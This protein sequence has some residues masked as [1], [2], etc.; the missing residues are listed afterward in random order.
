MSAGPRWATVSKSVLVALVAVGAALY[1]AGRVL[2]QDGRGGQAPASAP[3]DKPQPMAVSRL[4]DGAR[5]QTA[6]KPVP[7]STGAQMTPP[8]AG[9]GPLQ[10]LAITQ[11]DE[12]QRVEDLEGG[13][14]FSLSFAE[15]IPIRDLLLMLVRDTSLSIIPEPGLEGAFIG[16]LKNVTLRQALDLVLQPLGL[17]YSVEGNFIRV[18]KLRMETRIFDI[19]YV[20][21]RRAG[22]RA[23][24]ATTSAAG[25][26][27]A[28]GVGAGGVGIGF[29]GAAGGAGGAAGAGGAGTGGSSSTV[30]GTD[31]ADLFG[32][33]AEGLKTLLSEDGKF[34]LDRKASMLQVTD[35]PDRLAKVSLY[36][37]AVLARVNRQV[38]IQAKVIEVEL[39]DEFSAGINWSLVLGSAKNNVSLTQTLAPTTGGGFALGLNIK[40]FSALLSAFS[41]QG[42]VNVLSSPRVLAMNNEPAVIRVGTQDIFFVTTAQVDATTGR[43]LQTTVTP[44]PIT[45]GV[46]LSV[47]P[48]IGPDGVISMSVSPT[49]TERTGQATSRL[50]DTVPIISAREID[51]IVRV[52]QGETV[53]IGGLMQDRLSIDREKVPLLGDLPLIGGFFRREQKTKRKTDLVI[54]LTPTLMTPGEVAATAAREQQRLH[55]AQKAAMSKPKP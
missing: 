36:L 28:G 12:R 14:T 23:L 45:E 27:I 42:K 3:A 10:P 24:S 32:D 40:D 13:Q 4:E 31:S 39:R 8:P 44:Q 5:E 37:E 43:V 29:S 54:L 55:E 21:T 35:Y 50:G 51:T 26:G 47:T 19:N 11:L 22:T 9:Q 15:E 25:G 33:I 17:D 7:Q 30:S 1:V 18:F 2:A 46:V 38:Q 49:V 6:G 16:E 53:V 20:I 34:N 52:H 41:T 48:Q